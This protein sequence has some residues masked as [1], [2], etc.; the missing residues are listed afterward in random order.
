[1]DLHVYRNSQDRWYDLRS[2]ARD[3]GAV[4]AVNA[5]TLDELV[6]RLTPDVKTVTPGQRLAL[7]GTIAANVNVPN[8]ARYA[9]DAVNELKAARVRSLELRLAGELQLADLVDQY[10]RSLRDA[11]LYDPHERRALAASRVKETG[12]AWLQQFSRVVLHALYDLTESEF[13]LIRSLIEVLPDGGAV[14]VF[15]TTSNVKPTE[16]A[17]W[18]WQRFVQDESLAEKTFPEFCR[19]SR[20]SRAVLERLFVFGPEEPL[21]PDDSLRIVEASGRYHEVRTIGGEIADLLMRGELPGDIA[22]VVRHIDIY[23]EMIEDVF[24]RYGIPHSFE[25]G[26]PLL[27]IPFIKYWLCLLDLV[28]S[29]R[30]R[31][32]LSRIMSSAY[33]APRIS[34]K[35]DVERTLAGLGYIDRHHLRASALA[36]RRNSPFTPELQRFEQF[37][38]S[39][40]HST[41]TIMGYLSRLQPGASLTERDR[42]AWRVLVEELEGVGDISRT[43]LLDFAEFRKLASE[44]A[45]LRTAD[46]LISMPVPPGVPRVRVLSPHSLGYREYKWIFA[47][48]FADGEFPSRQNSNPLL[49]DETIEAINRSI[50]PRRI[51]TSRDRN[52]KEPLYLFMILDS[53]AN[54]VTITYPASTLEGNTIYPSIYVREILRHYREPSHSNRMPLEPRA[55]GEW[56]SAV[57]TEWRRGMFTEER[58]RH[59]LGDDLIQ[60]AQIESAGKARAD[61]RRNLLPTERVWHPSELNSLS[62]CPFV[63]LAS[64]VMRLRSSEM[65]DFEVPPLE[66]GI[67]IHAILRDFYTEPVPQSVDLARARMNEIVARR[68]AL[69]DIHGQGPYSVFDPSLWRIRR[70]QVVDVLNQYVNFATRDALDGFETQLEYLDQ[71]LPAAQLGGVLLSGRPDHVAVHRTRGRVDAI[72]VDDF[73]YSA[74]SSSTARLLK[75][76]FQIPIYTYLA[77]HALSVDDGARM[78]GRYLLLRSPGNPVVSHCL[79]GSVFDEMGNRIQSLVAKVKDGRLRPDPLDKQDCMDCEY[80]R[81]CRLYG[82]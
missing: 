65:P 61:I 52:R 32:A 22:V 10:N 3:R 36:A 25:T 70:E 50:R 40:E 72:R 33:F 16:F 18:T 58:A 76:S 11:G 82:G 63:F 41:D 62:E 79:D 6:E 56:L 27:R 75:D 73:K 47:P 77:S 39:V 54:R 2:A 55:Q 12:I 81:L 34:P 1:M 28:T 43:K 69:A 21:P 37:L 48:G 29:E 66:I 35:A 80:R 14:I 7:L 26:V 31:S 4:L 59:L 24:T 15:N 60:R 44:I 5:V 74:A 64:H 38:D 8:A 30:S 51:M 57:A 78:E 49:R 46:R 45:G 17:E 53:A 68:L 67:L 19:S 71:P 42:Q 9:Y 23:G 13:L 20:A